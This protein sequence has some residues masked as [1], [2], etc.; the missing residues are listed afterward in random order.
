[1]VTSGTRQEWERAD[2][3]SLVQAPKRIAAVADHLQIVALEAVARVAVALA[4]VALAAVARV[5][6]APAAGLRDVQ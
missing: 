5:A 2:I 3:A 6:F 4:A 1:M